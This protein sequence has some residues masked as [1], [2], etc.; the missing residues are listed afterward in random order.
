MQTITFSTY[1]IHLFWKADGSTHEASHDVHDT[2]VSVTQT[3]T[4]NT[5]TVTGDESPGQL[6]EVEA[7]A[8][9]CSKEIG[10]WLGVYMAD[11]NN[12]AVMWKNSYAIIHGSRRSLKD[13]IIQN[14]LEQ[15]Q[16]YE[17]DINTLEVYIGPSIRV[18]DYEVWSEFTDLFDQKYLPPYG[19]SIHLDMLRFIKNELQNLGVSKNNIIVHPDSTYKTNDT[20]Y[21]YRKGDEGLRNFMGISMKK[22]VT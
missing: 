9:V 13:W 6:H 11:C 5:Y 12:I 3:H 16:K 19:D 8:I 17:K 14:T 1:T 10:V 21:S 20:W 2:Y 4:G 7:D 22:K 18:D 15:M